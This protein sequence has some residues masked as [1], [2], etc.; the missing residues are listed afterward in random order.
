MRNW[1]RVLHILAF[2]IPSGLVAAQ[3]GVERPPPLG[4]RDF[5]LGPVSEGT[6]SLTVLRRIGKPD[7]I[8]TE[9][10]APDVRA[11]LIIWHY[12]HFRLYFTELSIHGVMAVEASDPTYATPRGLRVGDSSTRLK[13][14]YGEP[15]G[16]HR[17]TWDYS[18]PN[19]SIHLLRFTV[20][21]G[22]V[23]TIY[24]GWILD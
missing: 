19:S 5:H 7:S 20:Q 15:T 24:V 23:R 16:T 22:R 2:A 8:R 11:K 3:S 21:D 1:V 12:H 9:A 14:R 4:A 13:S 6:D 18:D 17:D 10:A